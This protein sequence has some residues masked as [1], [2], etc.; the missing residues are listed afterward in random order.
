VHTVRIDIATGYPAETLSSLARLD[1]LGST[2]HLDVKA[3]AEQLRP[4]TTAGISSAYIRNF[5][6][7]PPAISL[8]TAIVFMHRLDERRQDLSVLPITQCRH[9]ASPTFQDSSL[10]SCCATVRMRLLCTYITPQTIPSS[11]TVVSL[12]YLFDCPSSS[13]APAESRFRC[14]ISSGWCG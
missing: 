4:I 11:V 13:A 9:A 8:S 5:D 14:D 12:I 3:S 2:A 6:P 7:P 10:D 1:S